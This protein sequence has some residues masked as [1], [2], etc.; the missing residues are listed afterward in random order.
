M[1]WPRWRRS[2]RVAATSYSEKEHHACTRQRAA[3][4]HVEKMVLIELSI[5]WA[6]GMTAA[7]ERKYLKYSKLAA[8]CQPSG[9][10]VSGLYGLNRVP[11]APW[12]KRGGVKPAES[13]KGV[14]R[15]G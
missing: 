14:R 3:D 7:H 8:E 11:T 5:P 4:Y 2:C 6:E 13:Y 9:G 1:S 12:R 10:R 15:G